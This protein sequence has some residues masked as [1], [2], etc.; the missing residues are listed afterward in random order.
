MS[1]KVEDHYRA[2]QEHTAAHY[3]QLQ[4][5]FSSEVN[6]N[7]WCGSWLIPALPVPGLLPGAGQAGPCL[8]PLRCH[9]CLL[10]LLLG[11]QEQGRC[12]SGYQ[13][14]GK[15]LNPPEKYQEERGVPTCEAAKV[16]TS[17]FRWSC[18]CCWKPVWPMWICGSFWKG[19]ETAHKDE[20]QG[21]TACWTDKVNLQPA[22]FGCLPHQGAEEGGGLQHSRGESS[23]RK[24]NR[25]YLLK[26]TLLW[27]QPW[28]LLWMLQVKQID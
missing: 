15:P 20:T 23:E 24:W 28:P 21:A 27:L 5:H 25:L 17:D 4:I 11:H 7:G 9:W 10:H 14:E 8:Q 22:S 12:Q 16:F 3:A 6:Q 18:F 2:L 13:E 1:F 19:A 26:L